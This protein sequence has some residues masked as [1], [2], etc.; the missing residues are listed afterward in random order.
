[1]EFVP[2]PRLYITH[3]K[4]IVSPAAKLHLAVLI[5]KRKPCDVDWTRRHEDP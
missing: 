4:S 2:Y 5:V 1:M 3:F